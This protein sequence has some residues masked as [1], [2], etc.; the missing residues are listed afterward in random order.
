MTFNTCLY[1]AFFKNE[2][3]NWMLTPTPIGDGKL[4][5]SYQELANHVPWL[6][7]FIWL[8]EPIINRQLT[9]SFSYTK[10]LGMEF[11]KLK[12]TGIYNGG[13]ESNKYT[14][15]CLRKRP[16]T[17]PPTKWLSSRFSSR[18]V[19]LSK[20]VETLKGPNHRLSNLLCLPRSC[21][22]TSHLSTKSST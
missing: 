8:N 9:D 7:R 3:K 16:L 14:K 12:H 4:P 15:K 20:T 22:L 13:T 17:S 18:K 1:L 5:V 21:L 2:I 11:I 10:P 6:N 19:L